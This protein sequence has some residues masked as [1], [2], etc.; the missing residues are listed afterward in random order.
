MRDCRY[1][2]TQSQ[3]RPGKCAAT[4]GW[5]PRPERFNQ[6]LEASLRYAAVMLWTERRQQG[7]R[8]IR[9][10]SPEMSQNER[11]DAVYEAE[12]KT[13]D[14]RFGETQLRRSGVG[15]QPCYTRLLHQLGRACK[16]HMRPA[17]CPHLSERRSGMPNNSRR[18]VMVYRQSD[19]LIVLMKASNAAGGKEATQSHNPLRHLC[20]TQ[21]RNWR[22]TYR[23]RTPCV[24][25]NA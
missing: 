9:R 17:A 25:R 7:N 14:C 20:R 15:G 18:T 19:S 22:K 8:A 2:E 11:A 23:G 6:P 16:F 10:F 24:L 12:G 1:G 3:V 4:D 5:E 13:Q 21:M